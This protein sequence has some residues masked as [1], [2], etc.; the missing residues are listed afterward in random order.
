MKKFPEVC[1]FEG[2]ANPYE[3]NP[4]HTNQIKKKKKKTLTAKFFLAGNSVFNS[5]VFVILSVCPIN[6]TVRL[7]FNQASG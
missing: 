1:K 4:E 2:S 6:I 3:P 7:Y 5:L